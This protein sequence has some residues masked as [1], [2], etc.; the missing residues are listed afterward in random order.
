MKRDFE[1]GQRRGTIRY[2]DGQ[3]GKYVLQ[4]TG[5]KTGCRMSVYRLLSEEEYQNY[6]AAGQG[7]LFMDSLEH[8]R[9]LRLHLA[10]SREE[11]MQSL[12][13]VIGA[14]GYARWESCTG[15]APAFFPSE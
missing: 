9:W 3:G 7:G 2:T 10:S 6:R 11:A 5:G 15:F 12:R 1:H 8:A 13:S 4:E 14:R